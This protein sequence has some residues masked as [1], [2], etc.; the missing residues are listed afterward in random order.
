MIK[1][2][3]ISYYF[4]FNNKS[5][6]ETKLEIK[7]TLPNLNCKELQE[8]QNEHF[9]L[10]WYTSDHPLSKMIIKKG[11]V[12]LLILIGE[13]YEDVKI[14]PLNSFGEIVS[15]IDAINGNFNAIII[16]IK[17]KTVSLR[18]DFWAFNHMHYA[19]KNGALLIS[20]FIWPFAFSKM[21]KPISEINKQWI[22][23]KIALGRASSN[24]T[25]L[26]NVKLVQPDTIVTFYSN[27]NRLSER[28]FPIKISNFYASLNVATFFSIANRHL[29]YIKDNFKTHNICLTCTAG[30][31]SRVILNSMLNNNIKPSL[32]SLAISSSSEKDVKACKKI[33]KIKD[34]SINVLNYK[35][36]LSLQASLNFN[37]ELSVLLSNGSTRGAFSYFL[38]SFDDSYLTYWGFS[39]DKISELAHISHPLSAV[40]Q[41]FKKCYQFKFLPKI[42]DL[43]FNYESNLESDYLQTF[44]V[45]KDLPATDQLFYHFKNERNFHR[46]YDFSI[47]SKINSP[48]IYFYHDKQIID[49]YLSLPNN[50]KYYQRYHIY[51][52][53]YN[54]K[55]FKKLPLNNYPRADLTLFAS[56][57]L[58]K[59]VLKILMQRSNK[60]VQF[61]DKVE[62]YKYVQVYLK[63]YKYISLIL[64]YINLEYLFVL[65]TK[66]AITQNDFNRILT[67]IDSIL[68]LF[69]T[70][71]K[72]SFEYFSF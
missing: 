29:K 35:N 49:Y 46:I 25:F 62:F 1:Q 22:R 44:D 20:S 39:G 50:K 2:N 68:F 43:L 3:I 48:S 32:T 55:A 70:L 27:E 60:M 15:Q 26:S 41:S 7:A 8:I 71:E 65:T 18:T 53:Y 56:K 72:K 14:N 37:N 54:N 67:S 21:T 9:T 13:F 66:G 52:G 30:K 63:N 47:G 10:F 31:D 59:Y 33:A 45:L 4:E 12:Y 23:D 36:S 51:L 69:K 34:L 24:Q 5:S 28:F 6:K 40:Q 38:N 16:N 17:E 61:K 42:F 19:K 57:Y 11:D 64:P 58:S